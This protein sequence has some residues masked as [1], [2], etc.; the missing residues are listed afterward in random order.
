M[1]E[2]SRQHA[3]GHAAEA[4]DWFVL[5]QRE[6]ADI[7]E[8]TEAS[9]E[10]GEEAAEGTYLTAMQEEG[11]ARQFR[12]PLRPEASVRQVSAIELTLDTS[13]WDE[14]RTRARRPTDPWGTPRSIQP[15]PS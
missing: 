10:A 5:W 9:E 2:D 7:A 3:K 4:S 15:I 13:G 1:S 8:A 14:V 11:T 6:E 12:P